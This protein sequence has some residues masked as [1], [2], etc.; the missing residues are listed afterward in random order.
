MAR[1]FRLPFGTTGDR[2]TIPD[3]TDTTNGTV[4]YS[5]GYGDNY[6]L[7]P[8]T[9][10]AAL[11]VERLMFNQLA[12]DLSS[13][14]QLY[15]Q[16]GVPPFITSTDNGGTAY[17]Y[18]IGA[19]VRFNNRV[20][21]NLSAGNTN[22]PTG[23]GWLLVDAQG[24]DARFA[25]ISNNLSDLTNATTA[26]TNLD[27]GTAAVVDTGTGTAN[28]PTTAQADARY[29]T[30]T[31]A[32]GRYARQ[33][34]NLSDLDSAT[35]ARTNL[36]LGTAAV[37]DTGTGTANVPTTAQAD[38]RYYTRTA[39]DGRYARQSNNLSDLDNVGTARTN[40]DLGTAAVVD[41]GSGNNQV[42][43]NS[44]LGT[45]AVLDSGTAA[46][47]LPT[48]AQA[49]GRYARQSNNL[50]D[51]DSAT[52]ART[53]LDLGTAATLNTGTAA[54]NLPRNS[55][56]GSLSTLN[57]GTGGGD[58]RTNT[59]NDSRFLRI[60]NNLSEVTEATARTNLGLGTAATRN[61][62]TGN[63]R[64]MEV[65]A[66][67]LGSHAPLIR[68]DLDL[69]SSAVNQFYH[70]SNP[71][72]ASNRPSS[73]QNGSLI[74][75]SRTSLST[76]SQSNGQIALTS[77]NDLYIRIRMSTGYTAWKRLL[78]NTSNLSDLENA[79]SSRTNLG[80][81]SASLVDTGTAQDRIALVSD[82]GFGGFT[83][84]D[85]DGQSTEFSTPNDIN[86]NGMF[87][88]TNADGTEV[89][90][91]SGDWFIFSLVQGGASGNSTAGVKN[92][93]AI[94]AGQKAIKNLW[95]RGQDRA[96][97]TWSDWESVI[98]LIP[99][100]LNWGFGQFFSNFMN[101]NFFPGMY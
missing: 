2:A 69:P 72:N 78:T 7:N 66:F 68:D 81:R 25:Q 53:N 83:L 60:S 96:N 101:G 9:D 94:G 75:I 85:Q 86:R 54:G 27:L 87:Y 76:S 13:T 34:N 41:T 77:D 67:G 36:G 52:T 38:D 42:P 31:A 84:T 11:N 91:G 98:A 92:Q 71:Y 33:S 95:I 3:Q 46:G 12:F 24:A 40:L 22:E 73:N 97:N 43:L 8:A 57:S 99:M 44:N 47:N 19:R 50:S 58:F 26:R 49:D 90:P 17:S 18:A 100:F 32:D 48:T 28:V 15:Y 56:L 62:G 45:A 89:F 80:L 16:T 6:S 74:N 51:L 55:D 59:L 20:Y 10:Q 65:G 29:Y 63:N 1:Y 61:V 5:E 39:A 4:S 82:S 23:S 35:T 64:L 37:V 30:R 70:Y 79:S 93:L 88:F 21:E 14:L